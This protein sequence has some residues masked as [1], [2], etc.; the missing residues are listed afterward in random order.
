MP[1]KI[2]LDSL[3]EAI[4]SAVVHAQDHVEQQQLHRLL[5]YFDANG[6]PQTFSL[7]VPSRHPSAA[8][9]TEEVVGLPLLSLIPL[10]TLKIKD[11]TVT[12]DLALAD[13]TAGSPTAR[14]SLNI[15][16]HRRRGNTTQAHITV[17]LKGG[18]APEGAQRLVDYMNQSQGAPLPD[19]GSDAAQTLARKT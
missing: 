18:D 9:G 6:R 3:I 19:T 7:R 5:R 2:K 16:A 17:H 15:A 12:M 11:V 4:A 10:N 1:H 14:Q 8:P 13:F